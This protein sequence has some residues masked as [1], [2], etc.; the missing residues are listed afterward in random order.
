MG[1]KVRHFTAKLIVLQIPQISC[2]LDCTS[3]N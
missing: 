2:A 3:N 1:L